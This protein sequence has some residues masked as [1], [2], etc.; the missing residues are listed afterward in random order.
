MHGSGS[1]PGDAVAATWLINN[2]PTPQF[3]QDFADLLIAGGFGIDFISDFLSGVGLL[4]LEIAIQ[5]YSSLKDCTSASLGQPLMFTI[6]DLYDRTTLWDEMV[7]NST[8]S[9]LT[10]MMITHAP[11]EW[12]MA[13]IELSPTRADDIFQNLPVTYHVTDYLNA[14][15]NYPAFGTSYYNN[16]INQ[17]MSL[18][19]VSG[20]WNYTVG[21]HHIY[22]S[23]RIGVHQTAILLRTRYA[24]GDIFITLEDVE[25]TSLYRGKRHY[26]LSN[27]L[28]NVQV[29]VSDKRI[30]VCDS[31]LEVEYF[32]A[33]VLSAVD[34]YPFGMMMPDRQY[35]AS[36]DSSNYRY[37][38]NGQEKDNELS[39]IGN[40]V[41]FKYRVHDTRLGRFLSVDPL[42]HLYC[43]NSTYAFAE[44]TPIACIDLEG[45]EKYIATGPDADGFVQIT[46]VSD[47][48]ITQQQSANMPLVSWDEGK[49][50]TNDFKYTKLQFV[51]GSTYFENQQLYT[52]TDDKGN[53]VKPTQL[54]TGGNPETAN[55][56]GPN[57]PPAYWKP[58][59]VSSDSR[60]HQVQEKF[61]TTF[62]GFAFGEATET[63]ESV[64]YVAGVS[65]T[66][67]F[68]Y[69]MGSSA[70]PGQVWDISISDQSGNVLLSMTGVNTGGADLTQDVSGV[71]GVGTQ[72]LTVNVKP[73]STSVIPSG[74]AAY[75]TNYS[76]NLE[77]NATNVDPK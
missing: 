8:L 55:G 38:F 44:N 66:G 9:D 32:K 16:M 53:D 14:I 64:T 37:G 69:N 28:G 10:D 56:G 67:T 74:S 59:N 35:Y 27:H 54:N 11:G 2:A 40:S 6:L 45:K 75:A 3:Q 63:S 49:T 72:T 23:A 26:E 52:D 12:V 58:I 25:Y 46:L 21:E 20:G 51:F 33:E 13:A 29:V 43:W 71:L 77:I 17:L 62:G 57:R 22:G 73:S 1:Y 48:T 50:F 70:Y 41:S 19:Y 31:E 7:A 34:Y 65:A 47:Q 4:D 30:S 76:F 5:N 39:G 68:T 42:E 18:G 60:T 36:N 15:L 24:S 61:A